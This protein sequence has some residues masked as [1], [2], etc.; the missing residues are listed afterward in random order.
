MPS[1]QQPQQ[2]QVNISKIKSK[3]PKKKIL[4]KKGKVNLQPPISFHVQPYSMVEDIKNQ[5]V[6]ITFGQLIEI[7][8]RCKTELARGI[9]K[10]TIRKV[11]FSD[12]EPEGNQRSTAMYCDYT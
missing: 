6:R 9:R 12:M 5:Q 3:V 11:H 8:P 4:K 2:P 7:A 1:Q 10:P